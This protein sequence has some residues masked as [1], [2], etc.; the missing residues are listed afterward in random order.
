MFVTCLLAPTSRAP[1]AD[2]VSID[3][4]SHTEFIDFKR[5]LDAEMKRLQSK[6]IGSTKWQAEV[7]TREDEEKLWKEGLLGDTTPQ[8]LLGT[9]YFL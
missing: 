9:I 3:F 7:L 2:F 5:S 6:G 4:F 1:K 8:Q